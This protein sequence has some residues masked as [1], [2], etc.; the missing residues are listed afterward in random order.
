[1]T[2]FLR[3]AARFLVP[4]SL[5]LGAWELLVLSGA[6][7]PNVLVPPERVLAALLRLFHTGELQRNLAASGARALSGYA[8]GA[9]LGLL[10][11]GAM[12]L[13]RPVEAYLALTFHSLRQ[14]PSIAWVP[15]FMLLFGIQ[16]GFKLVLIAK[17]VLFPIALATF[18]GIRHAP[19]AQ[20][21]VGRLYGFGWRLRLQRIVLPAALPSIAT[22]LRLGLS[23]AWMMLVA[24]ELFASS[25]GIGHMMD[26]GRQL[27]QIDVVMAGVVITA[28]IGFALDAGLRGLERRAMPWREAAT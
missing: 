22:G 9:A 6:F 5:T 2:G 4:V 26:R 12:G 28:L 20:L 19:A 18:D 15:I 11:G 14:I 25:V 16:E 1:M 17:A 21:E 24:A 23:R 3:I 27:F 8:I 10:L 13:F 7:P